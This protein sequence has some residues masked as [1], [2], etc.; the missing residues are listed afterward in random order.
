MNI[1]PLKFSFHPSTLAFWV[2]MLPWCSLC[3]VWVTGLT[4]RLSVFAIPSKIAQQI[5]LNFDQFAT[6]CWKCVA[7]YPIDIGVEVCKCTST[8]SERWFCSTW[9]CLYRDCCRFCMQDSFDNNRFLKWRSLNESA[10]SHLCFIEDMA[11]S[12]R[13]S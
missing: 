10:C 11:L 1:S 6:R 13:L 3:H 2:L 9:K 8:C 12:S 5:M 7:V 4:C